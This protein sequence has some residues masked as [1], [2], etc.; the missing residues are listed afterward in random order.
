MSNLKYKKILL[1]IS[2]EALLGSQQFGIDP[3]PVHNICQEI[4]KAGAHSRGCHQIHTVFFKFLL[5]ASFI[6][7][8]NQHL[9][10]QI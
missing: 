4:K 8:E 5:A 1:K 9:F 10:Y 6:K 7:M 2:G 3:E